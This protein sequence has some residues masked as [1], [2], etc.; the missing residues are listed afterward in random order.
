MILICSG[1]I[2]DMIKSSGGKNVGREYEEKKR[3]VS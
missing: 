2:D 3:N 1:L